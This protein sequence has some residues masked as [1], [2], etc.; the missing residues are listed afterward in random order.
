MKRDAAQLRDEIRLREASLSD[1]SRERDAGELS[2]DQYE[3]IER[4]EGAGLETA[5]NELGTLLANVEA[6]PARHRRRRTKWLVVALAC[7]ALVIVYALVASSSPRQ[8][9]NSGDGGIDL[10]R[11]QNIDRLLNQA[12]ADVANN[13]DTTALSAY[14]RVLTLDPKNVTALTQSGWLD[15]TAGSA[16]KKASVVEVGIRELEKA[17]AV[18]PRQSAPRLYFAI[19][20]DSTPGNQGVAKTE[21]EEFLRLKPSVGQLAIARPFLKRLGIKI[22]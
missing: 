6:A 4:R 3:A 18:A 9:G 11:S 13:Q 21:F 20:A 12:E 8:A 22:P 2:T 15:F 19:V 7:F 1:A 16:A 10:T 17:I 5:R 14:A